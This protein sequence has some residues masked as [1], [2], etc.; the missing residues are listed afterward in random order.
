MPRPRSLL[1]SRLQHRVGGRAQLRAVVLLAA[2]L[3][4]DSADKASVGAVATQLEPALGIGNTRLGLLVTASI[5]V[6]ALATLPI[7]RWVDRVDRVRLL[8]AAIL[9]WSAAMVVC[10]AAT[11]Y[12]MLLAGRLALGAVAA[13]ATPVVASLTGDLFP[14]A[15][16]GRI[17]GYVLCGELLG[18]AAGILVS[19]NVAGLVSW[20][21]AFW[22]LV[23]PGVALAVA[24]R[25]Y[26]PEPPRGTQAA[27]SLSAADPLVSEQVHEAGV[28]PREELVVTGDPRDRS[29]AWAVRHVL[30][31]PTNRTLIVA[32]ALGYFFYSGVRTF[33]VVFVRGRFDVGQT[34]ATGLLVLV[35]L[36][37]VIGVLITGRTAD[38]LL[39]RGHL[40]ARP[41]VAGVS[42]LVAVVVFVPALLLHALAPALLLFA[43][44][45]AGVGGAN[46][47]TDAAR[48][49][50]VHFGL[51]GRAEAVR[52]VLKSGAE[53]IAP[54]LFGYV[55][56]RFGGG[57]ASYGT[58]GVGAT[59][60][61]A[62]VGRTYLVMLIPLLASAL[63][64]VR[65]RR[66]YPRDVATALAG[67]ERA[68]EEDD[69]SSSRA[70]QRDSGSPW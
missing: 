61:G 28:A 10:G 32:S 56:T 3:A 64:L 50:I 55:S 34:V 39:A 12:G 33:S 25:R 43:I 45:S 2:V 1:V 41:L 36:G 7:G 46:P 47:P 5:G 23:V 13:T 21:A 53:A 38:R 4:L 27:L 60:G 11:S 40:T 49:D 68:L 57:G 31:I 59:D 9:V 70:K 29:L 54:L 48:L 8:A 22:V 37:S 63:L 42:L 17:Y 51:W 18:A 62:G 15:D 69:Q 67:E 16:R 20:R 14:A 30:A 65:A 26:L 58:A 44:G 52:T 66:T 19:G 6:S 35:G 24:L